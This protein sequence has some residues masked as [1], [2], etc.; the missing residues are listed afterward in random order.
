M[1]TLVIK[2]KKPR[3]SNAPKNSL[4]T[5]FLPEEL[6]AEILPFFDVKTVTRLK[7]L[8]KSWMAFI[9]DSNFVQKHLKNSLQNPHLTLFWFQRNCCFN[10]VPFP[11]YR[12]LKNP[13][14]N[15][16]YSR[17]F[18]RL[19]HRLEES[20]EFV[21][22]C[23][24]L[25]CFHNYSETLARTHEL[26]FWNPATRTTSKK[27][28]SS[29][30]DSNWPDLGIFHFTFGYDASTRTYKVVAFRA[31]ENG[32]LWK[33][34]VKVFSLGDNCWRNI[35]SFPVVP[36]NWLNIS[37][38]RLNDGVHFSGT[39]NWLALDRSITHVKQIVIV[40]LDLSTETY[41]QFLLPPGFDVVPLFK[42]VL[43]VLMD[44]L[45]F[46]HDS[47]KTEFVLWQMKEYGVQE[48]W[49][50]LFKINLSY[51]QMHLPMHKDGFQLACLY[52][53]G[54]RVIFADK[55][56]KRAFIY[57]LKDKTIERI[58]N[59]NCI[60]WFDKAKDYVESLVSVC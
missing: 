15:L 28:G 20:C 53:N 6:L 9:S 34:Q 2:R 46:S 33:S 51:L 22:S 55:F 52:V 31:N 4:P 54:D 56:R 39:V 43:R 17:C 18:H 40:S 45:C 44:C 29:L 7:C 26:C 13:G 41:K 37:C 8:S 57:N 16:Y 32:G 24:G 10:V 48:S 3:Q 14:I 5:L 35:Q 12:L 27:L 42:P 38:R 23:N 36:F 59:R 1:D 30:C 49:T 58:K 60:H 21:G 11:V 50:Q 25:L 19:K 47:N